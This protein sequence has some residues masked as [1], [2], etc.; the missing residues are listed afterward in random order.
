MLGNASSKEEFVAVPREV[1]L[2]YGSCRYRKGAR[3]YLID[4]RGRKRAEA[5][6]GNEFRQVA[7]RSTWTST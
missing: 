5:A 3:V 6:L 4:K 2:C 7:A 1:V